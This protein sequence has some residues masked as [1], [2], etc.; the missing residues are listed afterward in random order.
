MIDKLKSVNRTVLEMDIGILCWGV[1]C[2]IVGC[3]LVQER[4]VYAASLWFGILLAMISTIHM[5]RSLD[6]ALDFDEKAASKLIYRS[7]LIRYAA[8]AAVLLAVMITGAMNPLVVFLA[9]MGL[10]V[11]A[12]LQPFTHR[13]CNKVF[14]EADPVP[15]AMPEEETGQTSKE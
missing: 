1:I 11:A 7:Y 13:L 9:Y 6:R 12:F 8:V 5:Y 10:K 14:H 4:G 2:Q 15:Q 3:L